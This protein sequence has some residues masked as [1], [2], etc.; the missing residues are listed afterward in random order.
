MFDGIDPSKRRQMTER[1]RKALQRLEHAAWVAVCDAL[2]AER[3][4]QRIARKH[5]RYAAK[6]NERLGPGGMGAALLMGEWIVQEMQK[7]Y[8]PPCP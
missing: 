2:K 1:E 6:L 4:A 3:Q 5:Q 7:A 8:P